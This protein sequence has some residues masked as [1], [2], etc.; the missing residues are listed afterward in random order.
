MAAHTADIQRLLEFKE[1]ASDD[2]EEDEKL[3]LVVQEMQTLKDQIYYMQQHILHLRAAGAKLSTA[4]DTPAAAEEQQLGTDAPGIPTNKLL[5]IEDYVKAMKDQ[6]E[7]RFREVQSRVE[8]V[9]DRVDTLESDAKKYNLIVRGLE[10][11]RVLERK[12]TISWH[13][14]FLGVC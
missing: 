10:Q 14:T 3:A 7:E 1:T 6:A 2:T 4:A 12:D 5:E 13:E 9:T 8:E 11:T